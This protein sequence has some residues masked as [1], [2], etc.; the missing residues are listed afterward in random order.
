[1]STKN[2]TKLIT[3]IRQKT[4]LGKPSHFYANA[5]EME[6]QFVNDVKVM[7]KQFEKLTDCF[8]LRNPWDESILGTIVSDI[9]GFMLANAERQGNNMEKTFKKAIMESR[10]V[11]RQGFAGK[12][13]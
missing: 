12:N 13:K 5:K 11:Y 7:T 9:V 3:A 4:N 6:R 10:E 1:M 2:S 8:D